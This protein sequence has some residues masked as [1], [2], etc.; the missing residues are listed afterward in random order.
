VQR[1]CIYE[2]GSSETPCTF[3]HTWPHAIPQV[4]TASVEGLGSLVQ[5]FFQFAGEIDNGQV[6]VI[7]FCQS[8][9]PTDQHR[10]N[11]SRVGVHFKSPKC[12]SGTG[13]SLLGLSQRT[14]SASPNTCGVD[15]VCVNLNNTI[16]AL[17]VRDVGDDGMLEECRAFTRR[18]H[19]A[20]LNERKQHGEVDTEEVLVQ[21][22]DG[23]T[24][25]DEANVTTGEQEGDPVVPGGFED[26]IAQM[27][28]MH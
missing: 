14:T 27:M 18:I 26:K 7:K 24:R 1:V 19:W 9:A 8:P 25:R 20:W 23:D 11:L 12:G 13:T 15:L 2:R 6:S 3:D 4:A 17:L 5:S 10:R 22:D 28:I 16:V 21:V